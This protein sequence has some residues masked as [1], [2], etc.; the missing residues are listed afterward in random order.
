MS[1]DTA[2]A[3]TSQT[4][5]SRVPDGVRA[6]A[7]LFVITAHCL[8]WTRTNDHGLSNIVSF[9]PGL[10]WT[11][12]I[13]Q[14]MP[15]FFFFAGTGLVKFGQEKSGKRYLMRGFMLLS[16][17]SFMYV[18]AFIVGIGMLPI[19][20]S[21]VGTT[22]GLLLVQLT[23]FL[24]VYLLIVAIT[25]LLSRFKSLGGI[26]VWLGLISGVDAL[27]I[28]VD[29]NL[30]WINM[31]LVW[32][33]FAL[34]G[35]R[36]R[37]LRHAP[38][39][40]AFLGFIISWI[41]AWAGIHWGPYSKALISV[42]GLSGLSNLGPPSIVLACAGVGQIFLVLA[43]WEVLERCFSH[44]IV[45]SVVGGFG[46]RSMQMYLHQMV[47]IMVGVAPFLLIESYPPAVNWL[48][49]LEHLGV[50][51]FTIACL[52]LSAPY[53]RRGADNF[54]RKVLVRVIPS[55]LAQ[56]TSRAPRGLARLILGVTGVLMLGLSGTGL[57][58]PFGVH[59][60]FSLPIRP[61]VLWT[62]VMMNL[63]IMATAAPRRGRDP[64]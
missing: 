48:W 5:A 46:M 3:A 21:V 42:P 24:A 37:D 22:V 20:N 58:D 40:L 26:A 31:I 53:L 52:W 54:S 8:A 55:A 63:A 11:T 13:V 41:C 34:I 18:F 16:P 33:W 45:W 7:L 49:W 57:N 61:V 32:S 27:R 51:A 14:I 62:V 30:G 64:E 1:T 4:S 9:N 36:I 19:K 12:W 17:A 2:A 50:L 47:F 44:R 23:W 35:M 56:W 38:K 25:P 28:H 6:L 10:W 43:G 15:L 29:Q 60:V 39:A 59:A